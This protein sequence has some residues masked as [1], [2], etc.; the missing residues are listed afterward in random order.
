[1]HPPRTSASESLMRPPR[2]SAPE[3]RMRSPRASASVIKSVNLSS[4][5]VA[6]ELPSAPVVRARLEEKPPSNTTQHSPQTP[7]SATNT[8]PPY[9]TLSQVKAINTVE[10]ES[11]E[12]LVLCGDPFQYVDWKFATQDA[13]EL[14]EGT[15]GQK[16]MRLQQYSG[17][18]AK[19]A[20]ADVLP[21]GSDGAHLAAKEEKP[22][23]IMV[24]SDCNA[25]SGGTC[26]NNF[27]MQGPDQMNSLLDMLFRFRKENIAVTCDI[28]RPFHQ[29][30]VLPDD[31]DFLHFIWLNSERETAAYRMKVHLFGARSSPGCMTFGIRALSDLSDHGCPSRAIANGFY[32]DDGLTSAVT[33]SEAIE[34]A[35]QAESKYMEVNLRLQKFSSNSRQVLESLSNSE[36]SIEEEQLLDPHIDTSPMERTL[37]ISWAIKSDCF[38]FDSQLKPRPSTRRDKETEN[39]HSFG[40]KDRFPDERTPECDRA[41]WIAWKYSLYEPRPETSQSINTKSLQP[42]RRREWW[43]AW[44]RACIDLIQLEA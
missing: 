11:S 43:I 19:A 39:G 9:E 6:S 36:R 13:A 15:P 27:I 44:H 38:K 33:K 41:W 2:T 28:E 1:M 29:F 42:E 22:G 12:P 32:A 26:I 8:H 23:K 24:V 35:G 10:H 5:V 25:K 4:R 30:R 16:P 37:G 20:V 17:G 34:P 18:E 3:S 21:L 7:W 14:V 31:R 40:E